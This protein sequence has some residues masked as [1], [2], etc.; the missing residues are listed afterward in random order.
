[1]TLLI[2]HIIL[3]TSEVLRVVTCVNLVSLYCVVC[4]C[5]HAKKKFFTGVFPFNEFYV[6]YCDTFSQVSKYR[7]RLSV[8][9]KHDHFLLT[10]RSFFLKLAGALYRGR[11][12]YQTSVSSVYKARD[13]MFVYLSSSLSTP[14]QQYP[15][16]ASTLSQLPRLKRP[17]HAM[18]VIQ[19]ARRIIAQRNGRRV[20]ESW[21]T[22]TCRLCG[23][24]AAGGKCRRT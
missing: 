21:C 5:L 10:T 24:A 11:Q 23:C 8:H 6:L 19:P 3:S 13:P 2:Y 4:C 22:R 12:V 9:D 20:L 15:S 1:M 17:H 18:A 14:P 7:I 16:T